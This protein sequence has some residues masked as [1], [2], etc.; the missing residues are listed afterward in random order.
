MHAQERVHMSHMC[1]EARGQPQESSSEMPPLRQGLS[2]AGGSPIRL[3]WLANK[4][5]E[6]SCLLLHRVGM[7]SLCYYTQYLLKCSE[8]SN[9]YPQAPYWQNH[10][11]DP[12]LIF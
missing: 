5:Q 7:M 9:S 1:V 4:S 12:L 2:L 11:W 8:G 10:A 6:S 3:D